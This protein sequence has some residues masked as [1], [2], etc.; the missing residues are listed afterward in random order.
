MSPT[1]HRIAAAATTLD[2]LLTGSSCWQILTLSTCGVAAVGAVDY[3]TGYEFSVTF[4]YLLPVAFASWYAGRG[5]SVGI[6]ALSCVTWYL[7]D[8]AS[9]HSYRY[10]AIPVWNALIRFMIFVVNGL[11][12]R[13]L[14]DSLLRQRELAHTDALTGVWGRR[15]FEERLEHDLAL[16]RRNGCPLTIAFLDLDDFKVLNDTRGHVVGDR[17]LR[18]TAQALK[19]ATRRA[20]MVARL[21]GD[22]FALVLPDTPGPG[23]T[24]AVAKLMQGVKEALGPVA[25]EVTCSVGVVTFE[26]TVPQLDEAVRAADDLMYQAKQEGRNRVVFAVA[27]ERAGTPAQ[28]RDAAGALPPMRP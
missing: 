20:D 23:A 28:S 1:R 17:A 10:P 24:E 2:R 25:P 3:L 5:A 9:G 12:L 4:F 15:A 22:E 27:R 13:A 18:A 19:G 7:A 8:A 11:L 16:A 21:G 26:G 6:A 14:R